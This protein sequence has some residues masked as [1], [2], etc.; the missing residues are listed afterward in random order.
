[1]TYTPVALVNLRGSW[2]WTLFG[3][4]WGLCLIGMVFKFF[5][6]Y[7]F[8]ILS[9]LI[10]I[11]MGWIGVITGNQLLT[12]IHTDGFLLLLIG[13]LSYT[14]G[15]V[16]YAWKRL[17]YHHAIWHLFVIVG[18]TCHYFAVMSYVLPL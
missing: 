12:H 16:F 9:P 1:V 18:S 2:G 5:F 13:G 8:K 14:G 6:V 17:P 7:R 4:V 15:I 11:F 3:I 10:Y